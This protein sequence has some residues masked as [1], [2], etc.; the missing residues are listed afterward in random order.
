MK[1]QENGIMKDHFWLALMFFI[2]W[3]GNSGMPRYLDKSALKIILGEKQK[4]SIT[5]E[6]NKILNQTQI[7][8]SYFLS[9]WRIKSKIEIDKSMEHLRKFHI[10]LIENLMKLEKNLNDLI[11]EK[12]QEKLTYLFQLGSYERFIITFNSLIISNKFN[13]V[14]SK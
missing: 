11:K 1:S 3:S 10:L 7:S 6:M 12:K 5:L 9:L 8:M 14:F 13:E 4:S 2:E